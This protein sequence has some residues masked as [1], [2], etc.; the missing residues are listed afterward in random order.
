MPACPNQIPSN[1]PAAYIDITTKLP[2]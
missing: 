1:E 2:A